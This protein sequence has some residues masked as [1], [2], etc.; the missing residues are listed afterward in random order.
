VRVNGKRVETERNGRIT[1]TVRLTGLPKGRFTVDI[2][3]RT[4]KGRTLTGQRKYR[5]CTPKRPGGVPKL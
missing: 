1:A 2:T 4:R 3:A 5:T